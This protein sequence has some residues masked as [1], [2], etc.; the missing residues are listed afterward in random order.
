VSLI[1]QVYQVRVRKVRHGGKISTS[2]V[3]S[4]KVHEGNFLPGSAPGCA[5]TFLKASHSRLLALV[6]RLV[7][8]T[9]LWLEEADPEAA[10]SK[11]G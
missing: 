4:L 10:V 7:S 11:G 9:V 2:K 8:G 3:P 1:R 5:A 6:A